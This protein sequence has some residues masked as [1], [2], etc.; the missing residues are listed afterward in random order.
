M[1]PS[2]GQKVAHDVHVPLLSLLSLLSLLL[3]RRPSNALARRFVPLEPHKAT[4]Q[5]RHLPVAAASH[6]LCQTPRHRAALPADW[7][8]LWFKGSIRTRMV[9]QEDPSTGTIVVRLAPSGGTAP[10][11]HMHALWRFLPGAEGRR[12]AWRRAAAARAA[13]HPPSRN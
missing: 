9:V 11:Q 6:P 2:L 13:P 5:G 3:L 1:Q 10:L 12:G 8:F 7:H 4:A